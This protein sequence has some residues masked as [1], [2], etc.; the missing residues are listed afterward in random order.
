MTWRFFEK[1]LLL[2]FLL[3]AFSAQAW[4]PR[5]KADSVLER[6]DPPPVIGKHRPY[7]IG[8]GETLM[9]IARRAGV[10]FLA[11][12]RANPGLDPWGPPAGLEIELPYS[13][14][15]P[16]GTGPGI[17]INLA[18]LRLY[19]IWSEDDISRVRIYPIGIGQEGLETPEGT[20]YLA[21][22]ATNPSWTVPASIRQQNPEM[23]GVVPP[24]PDNP[25][26]GYWLGLSEH[27]IGIHGTNRPYGVGRR[28]SHGCI[29][30]Y[31]ED[32]HNLAELSQTGSAVSII[33]QPFKLG[34]SGDALYLEAHPDYLERIDAPLSLLEQ[35]ALAL[36]WTQ[37]LDTNKL[38]AVIQKA[39]GIPH[40]ISQALNSAKTPLR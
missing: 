39:D 18:E 26:G 8:P 32:I 16:H 14:I 25:L 38:Q 12:T 33:Y 2:A 7:V 6:L 13:A 24:G 21:N 28:V 22:R 11:L 20:F 27:N 35:Q 1:I 37:P 30:L 3:P 29:R 34:L 9:E 5:L 23:P 15:L 17:T 4:Q 40:P 19:Y 31:P 36:G 10:G